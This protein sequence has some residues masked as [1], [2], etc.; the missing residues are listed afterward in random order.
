MKMASGLKRKVYLKIWKFFTWRVFPTWDFSYM[1]EMLHEYLNQMSKDTYENGYHVS[2]K[3]NAKRIAVASELAKRIGDTTAF[4]EAHYG[5]PET[6]LWTTPC[7]DGICEE[8]HTSCDEPLAK[9]KS[10]WRKEEELEKYY[11]GY[12]TKL[13][14]QYSRGWWE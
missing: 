11:L 3:R 8:I 6:K 4:E 12:F 2:S 7:D 1:Y 14:R 10:R 5:A 13:L 9:S